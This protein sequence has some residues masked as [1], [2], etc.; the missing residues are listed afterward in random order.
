MCESFAGYA[1]FVMSVC[2]RCQT[3]CLF[4]VFDVK[5]SFASS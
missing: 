2:D 1:K 5:V 4:Y 3:G